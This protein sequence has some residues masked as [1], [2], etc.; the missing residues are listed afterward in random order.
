MDE[1]VCSLCQKNWPEENDLTLLCSNPDCKPLE[2]HLF[3]LDSDLRSVPEDRDW[4]CPGCHPFGNLIDLLK[5]FEWRKTITATRSL[6]EGFF[7]YAHD[8]DTV[9]MTLRLH[10]PF[11]TQGTHIGS[12]L[13]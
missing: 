5:Y 4:F 1:G 12:L 11:P 13:F 3:C 8:G 10:I 6:N 2:C 9:G 7:R